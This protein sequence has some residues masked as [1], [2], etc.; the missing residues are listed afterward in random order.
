[1]LMLLFLGQIFFLFPH[2]LKKE[3]PQ[4][5]PADVV[6]PW[7]QILQYLLTS[8]PPDVWPNILTPTFLLCFYGV[9][10]ILLNWRKV[11]TEVRLNFFVFTGSVHWTTS[12][13][14]LVEK[15]TQTVAPPPPRPQTK[16][17]KC[18]IFLLLTHLLDLIFPSFYYRF[19]AFAPSVFWLKLLNLDNFQS[20]SGKQ[21]RSQVKVET[22][23][24]EAVPDFCF[25][26]SLS[27]R[28]ILIIR[29]SSFNVS[30]KVLDYISLWEDFAVVTI[31][32]LLY[33]LYLKNYRTTFIMAVTLITFK[34]IESQ[35]RF[36]FI[37]INYNNNIPIYFFWI[38]LKNCMCFIDG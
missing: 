17:L 5:R 13:I 32:V 31:T 23:F 21:H 26:L 24:S 38:L 30:V 2:S 3:R 22:N 33:L 19:Y 15:H 14:L 28:R 8:R 1:M 4:T 16:G 20:S 29:M 12:P 7:P 35:C 36:G 10:I 34:S 9:V 11:K 37:T 6:S 25:F 18:N 27:S